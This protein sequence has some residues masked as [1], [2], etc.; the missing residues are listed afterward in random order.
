M[1]CPTVGKGKLWSS[2]P[3]QVDRQGCH[4]TVKSPDPKCSF[5]K[6]CRDKNGEENEGKAVQ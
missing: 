2:P 6:N 5:V 3:F 1:K 4:P